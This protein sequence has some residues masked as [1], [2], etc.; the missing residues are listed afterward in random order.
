MEYN[1]RE[2]IVYGGAF[3]P[4]T[5]A[6]QA[7]LQACIDYAEPRHADVWLLPSASRR[8]KEIQT[9]SE[10]RLE[11]CDALVGDVMKRMVDVSVNRMELDRQGMTETR[12]TVRELSAT[13][14][15]RSFT[16]VYGSDAVESMP[17]WRGGE[18][19][20]DNLSM[21][22]IDRPGILLETLGAN[23]VRLSVY[24]DD[25]SSTE[26][27]RRLHD[28]EVCD[29]LVSPGVASLLARSVVS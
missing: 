27:R 25:V 12:E 21:L 1:T 4:P 3:N 11:L 26:V 15:D 10:R 7:I 9:T 29:D 23:A 6:H 16:W 28:G 2:T 14:P 18:W 22:V 17:S 24:T 19:L 13:Y 5:K 20:R 8:D